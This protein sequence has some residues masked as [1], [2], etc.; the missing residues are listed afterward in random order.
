MALRDVLQFP[1]KRLRRVSQPIGAI[2]DEIRALA[3][4]MCE[5]MYD[6]PGIGLAAPQVGEAI[7]LIVVDTEWTEEDAERNPLILV[8]PQL[9][10]H[11]GK[12]V[13]TEGCLS[14]PD[15]Q[16]EVERAARVRLRAQ[17]L[18]GD[19]VDIRAEDVQAVCFQH[20]VDH[21]DGVLFIDHISRLKRSRYEMRRKKQ[22]RREQE[23]EA[24]AQV[25][26]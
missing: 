20:E 14:V 10:E 17:T 24:G 4:D 6:E 1:D 8:N 22:L 11:E 5:V 21:L 9:S 19:E 16:A 18:D 3:H 2:T 15:F 12:I 7:R 26:A 23:E 13:W 25:P